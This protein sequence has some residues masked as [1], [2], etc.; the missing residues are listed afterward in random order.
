MCVPPE[1]KEII[2]IIGKKIVLRDIIKEI[3][4]MGLHSIFAN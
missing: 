3:E 1:K 2:E 4:K